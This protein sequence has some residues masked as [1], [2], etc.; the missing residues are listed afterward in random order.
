[1]E[2]QPSPWE[3]ISSL[4]RLCSQ[5]LFATPDPK[6]PTA[7]RNYLVYRRG[8]VRGEEERGGKKRHLE[9]RIQITVSIKETV[10]AENTFKRQGDH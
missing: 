2:T 1:M 8:E 9:F 5:G 10:A 4:S 7:S 3:P 6:T